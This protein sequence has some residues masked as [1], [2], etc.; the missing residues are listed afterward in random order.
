MSTNFKKFVVIPLMVIGFA[1]AC[2]PE[3]DDPIPYLPFADII[4]N[5]SLPENYTLQFN[6][7]FKYLGGGVKGIILYHGTGS[8]FY[9]FERNCSFQPNDACST[10]EMENTNLRLIDPCCS[11]VFNFDGNPTS[12]P[13][14]KPLRQYRVDAQGT[15]LT[16]TDEVIN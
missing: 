6:G 4:V 13:A 12:G 9:A 15:T 1:L 5:L 16:V 14:R 7:G 10:V 8:T 3:S 2:K 11:S